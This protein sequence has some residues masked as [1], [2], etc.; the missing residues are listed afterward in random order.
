MKL[1]KGKIKNLVG[2][3]LQPYFLCK[4][5]STKGQSRIC[6]HLTSSLHFSKITYYYP[7]KKPPADVFLLPL[8]SLSLSLPFSF[9]LYK[10]KKVYFYVLSSN[11]FKYSKTAA[12]PVAL[13]E[14]KGPVIWKNIFLNIQKKLP[15]NCLFGGEGAYHLSVFEIC[16]ENVFIAVS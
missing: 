13:L 8:L 7:T 12:N 1:L 11:Y 6:N 15:T 3:T 9:F 2:L 5:K 10:E 14:E 16:V 4:I